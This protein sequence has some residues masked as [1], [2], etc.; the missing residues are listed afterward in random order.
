M[1]IF[2]RGKYFLM[3]W[4]G[5]GLEYEGNV[6]PTSFPSRLYTPSVNIARNRQLNHGLAAHMPI[7]LKLF[8]ATELLVN[9]SISRRITLQIEELRHDGPPGFSLCTSTSTITWKIHDYLAICVGQKKYEIAWY[10]YRRGEWA[11][12]LIIVGE[13]TQKYEHYSQY[14]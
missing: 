4:P 1:G 11:L 2:W 8:W 14:V 12:I 3:L 7:L 13:I 10:R 6:E 9:F 5:K